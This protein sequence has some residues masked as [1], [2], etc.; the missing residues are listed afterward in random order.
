MTDVALATSI[1]P[2]MRRPGPGG[3]EAGPA[4]RAACAASWCAA[5][6]RVMTVNPEA[7]I[8]RLGDLPPGLETVAAEPGVAETYGRPGAWISDALGRAIATGAP[9]VGL[10][11]ADILFDLDPVQRA[12]LVERAAQGMVACNRTD[13]LHRHQGE[14]IAYR[15]GYDL[16]LMPRALALRLDVSGFAFGVPWWDYWIVLDAMLQDLP[17]TAA[18]CEGIR[19]LAHVPA[20]DRTGW[21]LALAML[22][23]RLAPRRADLSRLAPGPVA[24]AMADLLLAVAPEGEAGY[25]VDDLMVISGTRFG[26]ELVR[27]AERNAWRLEKP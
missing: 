23:R 7:E 26:I 17:V 11:N 22:M 8:G 2:M 10:V 1:P 13:V 5:G 20:W 4:W 24:E 27:M 16:V 21:R 14:G 6:W 9:V 25:P 18:Q 3:I 12:A 19:H 15:Y